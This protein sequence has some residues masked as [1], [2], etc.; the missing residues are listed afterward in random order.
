MCLES[1]R[2]LPK[3]A[4][5]D[6]VV[7]KV[8]HFTGGKLVTS[9]RSYPITNTVLKTNWRLFDILK[10]LFKKCHDRYIIEG[11]MFHSYNIDTAYGDFKESVLSGTVDGIALY[12]KTVIPKG[13]LYYKDYWGHTY[14]SNK[15]ILMPSKEQLPYFENK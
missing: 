15:L 10:L 12:V 2:L 9:I 1:T 8:L 11:G 13:A 5:E 6:I 3:R 14:A 4:K 7:G